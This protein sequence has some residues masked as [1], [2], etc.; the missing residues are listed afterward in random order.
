M[1]N[2]NYFLPENYINNNDGK[3]ITLDEDK[4]YVAE[5]SYWSKE[6]IN[7]ALSYQSP[8]YRYVASKI[9]KNLYVMDVGCGVG[10]KLNNIIGNKTSNIYG[11]DQSSA[12]QKA[13]EL[14]TLPN[15]SSV[16]FDNESTWSLPKSKIDFVI[17]CD[18]IEHLEKP[19]NLLNYIKYISSKE[20]KIFISTPNRDRV[21]GLRNL[22]SPNQAHIR[23]WNNNEF[24]KFVESYSLEIVNITHHYPYSLWK[25]GLKNSLIDW[26]NIKFKSKGNFKYNMLFEL[27]L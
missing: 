26:F 23:E 10:A 13:K 18:V 11:V 6:R 21:R 7:L 16:D 3:N 17:S 20:T 8:I 19:Q 27:K 15:F 25:H 4:D 2:K 14:F 22:Q 5:T 24:S 12:I 9:T 1:N